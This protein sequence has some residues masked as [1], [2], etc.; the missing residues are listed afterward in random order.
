MVPGLG[1]IIATVIASIVGFAISPVVGLI[2]LTLFTGIQQL[3]NNFLVPKVMQKVTG[4]NP[5]VTMIAL[6]IGGKLFGIVGAIISIP[7][8]LIVVVTFHRL[9]NLD[10]G[11]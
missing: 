4:F 3:E 2:V 11:S 5:L 10:L 1:P 9:I 7:V 6:L 8:A